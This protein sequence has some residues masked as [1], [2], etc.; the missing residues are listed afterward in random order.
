MESIAH[1]SKM[2]GQYVPGREDCLAALRHLSAKQRQDLFGEDHWHRRNAE[3]YLYEAL[4]YEGML[5]IAEDTKEIRGIVRR[6]ADAPRKRPR[7]RLGQ[8][9]L[10]HDA[11]G[12][13]VMRGNGQ[14]LGELDIIAVDRYSNPIFIEA[15]ISRNNLRDFDKEIDHKRAILQA[16]L[17]KETVPFLIVSPV[18]LKTSSIMKRILRNPASHYVQTCL[19][20]TARSSLKRQDIGRG[21]R[22]PREHPSLLHL[23]TVRVDKSFD[24]K[25]LHDRIRKQI[26]DVVR[27][28]E[29]VKD[30]KNSL[31]DPPLVSKVIIGKLQRNDAGYLGEE[32]C[33]QVGKRRLSPKEI[34][35]YFSEVVLAVG[36]P[37]IRPV[38]YMKIREKHQIKKRTGAYLK[39]GP[40]TRHMFG[41]EK[42]VRA[43]TGFDL[44]LNSV[45]HKIDVNTTRNI[46]DAF[47]RKEILG[48]RRKKGPQNLHITRSSPA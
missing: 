13:I 12:A 1:L 9:G 40:A 2:I 26:L 21:G 47:L 48:R 5:H 33:I 38:I 30:L 11:K 37:D 46:M 45:P 14:D 24:Y 10:F 36:L 25:R 8:N 22:K 41:F 4:I 44:W 42:M 3:G 39:V 7:S 17:G 27:R 15:M 16:L 23:N 18:D 19:V 28:C 31:D 35:E 20:E 34:D 43:F 6:I 29:D 32:I